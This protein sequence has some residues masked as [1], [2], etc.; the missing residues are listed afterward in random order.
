MESS[1]SRGPSSLPPHRRDETCALP[2]KSRAEF[3]FLR[4]ALFLQS[5]DLRR[6]L[7]YQRFD[8][9]E[10]SRGLC[11]ANLVIQEKLFLRDLSPVHGIDFRDFFFLVFSE[12]D[13]RRAL[14]ESFHR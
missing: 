14:F 12:R 9:V 7:F 3:F 4:F 5:A 13:R 10:L 1:Q 6:K 2:S 8:F 11:L